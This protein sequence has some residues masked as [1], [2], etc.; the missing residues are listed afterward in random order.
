MK[1]FLNALLD[2]AA[3]LVASVLFVVFVVGSGLVGGLATA[4]GVY[5]ALSGIVL[6]A[7]E[8][9]LAPAFS[10]IL[11]WTL[12]FGLTTASRSGR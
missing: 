11:F 8:P 10:E 5:L 2:G 9:R 12:W 6:V 4:V 1:R 7:V 3:L